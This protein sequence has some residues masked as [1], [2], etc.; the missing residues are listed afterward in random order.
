[1]TFKYD[2]QFG[3]LYVPNQTIRIP[4]KEKPYYIRTNDIGFRSDF[5]FIEKKVGKKKRILFL[6]DSNTAGDACLIDNSQR[7]SDILSRSL[8]DA[9]CYNFALGGSSLSQ[10]VLIYERTARQYEHDIVCLSFHLRQDLQRDRPTGLFIDRATGSKMVVQKPCF[11]LEGDELVILNDP[12]PNKITPLSEDGDLA[13]P[14]PLSNIKGTIWRMMKAKA[15]EQGTTRVPRVIIE[16]ME[17]FRKRKILR[18]YSDPSSDD[19]KLMKRII[20]RLVELAEGK[21][22]ILCPLPDPRA[23]NP[24]LDPLF[25]ELDAEFDNLIYLDLLTYFNRTLSRS[26]RW[27]LYTKTTRHYNERGHRLVADII[28]ECLVENGLIT[29]RNGEDQGPD[30]SSLPA[31]SG[32]DSFVLGISALYHDSACALIKNG[33]I[34]SAAQ[35]ERFTRIKNDFQFPY[36]AL[37][38]CLE[39]AGIQVDDLDAIVFYDNP[40]ETLERIVASQLAVAPAGEEIWLNM[41]PRWVLSKMRV[42][43]LIRNTLDYTN[44]LFFSNHHL[45]HAASAFFPSP[46]EEAAILTIDG[47][48]EWATACIGHGKNNRI[49]LKKQLEFPHSLGL[50]YSAFTYYTGFRVNRGEY[51]LMGLAP[52]GEPKYANLIKEH[53]ITIKQDGSIILNMDYFGYLDRM[54]M[55]NE[56]FHELFGGPPRKPES[57][58]TRKEMD[59][60]KSIQVVTEEIVLKMADHA[61]ELTG[62][63]HLCM[64][65][66]VALNCV[67]NGRLLREG[68]FKDIWI[69]PAAGDAG[70]ALGAALIHHYSKNNGKRLMERETPSI[71]GGSLWGPSFS[72]AEVG[73]HLDAYGYSYRRIDPDERASL[74]ASYLAEGKVVGHFSGRMEYGP[75]ALGARSIMG[76]PRDESTQSTINLKIKYR[77]SFRPFAPTVLVEDIQEYFDLDRPSPY[78]LLVTQVKNDRCLSTTSEMDIIRKVNQKRSDI[79]AITHVDYSARI[80]SID[81]RDHPEYHEAISEFK[82]NTGYGV[83]VNTSFNVRGEPIVCTPYDALN[84]FMNTEMDVLAIEDYILLKSE[85]RNPI[86]KKGTLTETAESR[87]IVKTSTESNLE[88]KALKFFLKYIVPLS[89]QIS[90]PLKMKPEI[91]DSNWEDK[92]TPFDLFRVPSGDIDLENELEL[93]LGFWSVFP[94]EAKSLLKPLITQLIKLKKKYPIEDYTGGDVISESIYVMF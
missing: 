23:G 45:S 51:K 5:N 14:S 93:Y 19:W 36:R 28:G 48:G 6:G 55:T 40:M 1:M 74:I 90:N 89:R 35:E 64:A 83:I 73:A 88:R 85:Q 30:E 79:P 60:A 80:Q 75:R 27:S 25:H 92:A 4:N 31:I 50:L 66:G 17:N 58:L 24:D 53:L 82:R 76:D 39:E 46:F 77:E 49:D 61:F 12:V 65:G 11:K 32:E 78:M 7:F 15:R 34:V 13:K 2:S 68:R 26:E 72:N 67:S 69:Q 37:N 47:V 16:R 8:G 57:E 3:T 38:Y 94:S 87:T 44:D 52:Y 91:S 43:E 21:P 22:V 29:R 63:D 33:D 20:M 84:C 42:P 70:G 18:T 81:R 86:F 71:Q 10:Q 62:C 54:C 9:E 41:L 59:I 56:A